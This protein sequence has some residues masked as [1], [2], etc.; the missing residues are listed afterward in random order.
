MQFFWH[1]CSNFHWSYIVNINN[2]SEMGT[3]FSS[4][5]CSKN[6]KR[7]K[8]KKVWYK[9]W[10]TYV[11]YCLRDNRTVHFSV[12][13]LFPGC[14]WGLFLKTLSPAFIVFLLIFWK[15]LYIIIHASSDNNS[16]YKIRTHIFLIDWSYMFIFVLI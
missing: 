6:K 12:C 7:K 3:N 2:T 8:G 4:L 14:T 5:N 1:V 16:S 13:L 9:L 10:F 15:D 11:I